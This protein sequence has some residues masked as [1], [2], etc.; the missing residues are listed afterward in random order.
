MLEKESFEGF[1]ESYLH[2]LNLQKQIALANF[3]N[4]DKLFPLYSFKSSIFEH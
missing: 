3:P 1:K 2:K 4:V